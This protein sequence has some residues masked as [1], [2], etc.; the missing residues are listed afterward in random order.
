MRIC[1]SSRKVNGDWESLLASYRRF[2]TPS[3]TVLEIGASVRERTEELARHCSA[4]IG[5][6]IDPARIPADFGRVRYRQ[7]DWQALSQAVVPASIDVAVASH[8]LEH[9]PDDRR[10]IQELYAVLKPGGVG[11]MNTPNRQRLTR[12][13]VELVTG[14]RRFPHWEHQREYVEADLQALLAGSPFSRYDIRPLVFGLHGG[15]VFVYRETV[16]PWARGWANYWE[17]HVFKE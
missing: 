5:V 2:V 16:P 4:L 9:V 3:A 6:E 12:R 1:A 7:A 8:V 14:P 11:L 13:A 15:P 17:I 10:A